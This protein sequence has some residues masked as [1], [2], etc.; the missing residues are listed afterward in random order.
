MRGLSH[1]LRARRTPTAVIGA[2]GVVWG[3]WALWTAMSPPGA[4]PAPMSMA[5]T[6]LAVIAAGTT[7][8]GPDSHLDHTAALPWPP[9]R[10]LHLFLAALGVLGLLLSVAGTAHGYGEPAVLARNCA[11][12]FGLISLGAATLGGARSWFYLVPFITVPPFLPVSRTT[13]DSFLGQVFSWPLQPADSGTAATVAVV[14][15][16]IG[17]ATYIHRGSTSHHC[18]Q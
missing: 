10:A 3:L 1:H 8:T 4:L 16:I 14:M 12:A 6:G 17:A 18:G 15:L 11:G 2:A 13:T 5:A 9:R 7:L